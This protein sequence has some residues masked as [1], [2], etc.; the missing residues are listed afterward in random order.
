MTPWK[1]LQITGVWWNKRQVPVMPY[2]FS[3]HGST[4][5][6]AAGTRNVQFSSQVLLPALRTPHLGLES[7][8]GARNVP[9]LWTVVN[10]RKCPWCLHT[11]THSHAH[12]CLLF[13][14]S[15][16]D[17]VIILKGREGNN[18]YKYPAQI[19]SMYTSEPF[20]WLLWKRSP[21][22]LSV[23]VNPDALHSHCLA[24]LL[25]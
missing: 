16:H 6:S 5:T 25:T 24:A 7:R 9:S 1:E 15:R 18:T 10:D 21:F 4:M 20:L 2:T 13:W 19:T 11:H 8:T 22:F 12:Q 14:V 17:C 23:F 3:R